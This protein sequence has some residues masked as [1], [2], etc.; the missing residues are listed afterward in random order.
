MSS[1]DGSAANQPL[2]R[3]GRIVRR[4]PIVLV[5]HNEEGHTFAEQTHTVMLS[6]HGAGI[7]STRIFAPEQE[8]TLRV[9]E[10]GRET[11]VR[12]VGE[13]AKEGDLHT[14]GVAFLDEGLDFWQTEFPPAPAQDVAPMALTLECGSCGQRVEVRSGQFEYDISQIH[15]GLTRNCAEC[16]ALTVWRR[17]TGKGAS[18]ADEDNPPQAQNKAESEVVGEEKRFVRS[19]T[20]L[21]SGSRSDAP[22]DPFFQHHKLTTGAQKSGWRDELSGVEEA[23]VPRTAKNFSG[24]AQDKDVEVPDRIPASTIEEDL[25][26]PESPPVLEPVRD[27][28]VERRGR[29]R[30]RVNFF[31][32]VKTPQF[33]PDIVTCLDMS[34][35]GVGFRSRNA[36]R[37]DMKIQ[38]AVPYSPEAKDAPA[39]FVAGRIANVRKAEGMWRCGVEFVK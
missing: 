38:I 36:Y 23:G 24:L 16:G 35:G 18:V 34:K 15:G 9:E 1:A 28:T 13:I 17:A 14:Y 21:A 8:L 30:A 32:C 39:I 22:S 11:V 33:G 4:V 31:A 5:G 6:L 29:A 12:V 27:P 19:E 2:R 37:K 20:G 10:S 7:L 3:S 25:G 26:E